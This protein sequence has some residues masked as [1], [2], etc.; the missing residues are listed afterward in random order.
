MVIVHAC[1]LLLS[2]RGST[3]CYFRAR[4]LEQDPEWISTVLHPEQLHQKAEHNDEYAEP[5]VYADPLL[6]R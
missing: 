1:L 5:Q 6:V 4:S 3:A 2:M